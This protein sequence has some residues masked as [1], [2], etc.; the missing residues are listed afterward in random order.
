MDDAEAIKKKKLE[1]LQRRQAEAAQQQ[2]GVDEAQ[3]RQAEELQKEAVMRAL[4]TP[5]ARERLARVKMA[6]PD[7]GAQVENLIMQLAQQGRIQQK[8][9]EEQLL[10]LLRQIQGEKK[11]FK[12]L[13]K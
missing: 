13:R 7:F 5:E 11:D 2:Q 9:S 8:M 1:E 3:A 6:R 10:A 12:I 4:L